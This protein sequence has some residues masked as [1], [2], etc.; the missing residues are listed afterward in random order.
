MDT[1]SQTHLNPS[2]AQVPFE[3][4]RSVPDVE[5]HTVLRDVP[6]VECVPEP[7]IECNDVAVD[8]PFLEPAEECEEIVFDDCVEV[9]K[10]PTPD[11]FQERFYKYELAHSV[12]IKDEYSVHLLF[13]R[14]NISGFNVCQ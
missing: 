8:I 7:Y 1:C 4:C 12:N 6:D 9:S 13:R 10:Q 11:V 3:T 2:F 5:C 14:G